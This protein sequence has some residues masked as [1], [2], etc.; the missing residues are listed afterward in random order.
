MVDTLNTFKKNL[1][2][3]ILRNGD[4]CFISFLTKSSGLTIPDFVAEQDKLETTFELQLNAAIPIKNLRLDED[5][6]FG[7]LS[8]KKQPHDCYVPWDAVTSIRAKNGS[9]HNIDLSSKDTKLNP[10]IK[11]S[12]QP[13]KTKATQKF[14]KQLVIPP[15]LRV[16]K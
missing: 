12:A 10:N 9:L 5:G 16:V 11:I 2:V 13:S 15:Y 4:S 8:F 3:S 1:A 7:T 14:K 6:F